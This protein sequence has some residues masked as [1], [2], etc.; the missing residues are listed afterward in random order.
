V[1]H[2]AI[3]YEGT[4][5]KATSVR[6]IVSSFYLSARPTFPHKVS[7]ALTAAAPWQAECEAHLRHTEIIDRIQTLRARVK[8]GV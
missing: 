1:K 3:V 7:S 8:R 2:H 6:A 5:F 4:G